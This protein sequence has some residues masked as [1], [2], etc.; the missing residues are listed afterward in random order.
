MKTTLSGK[1]LNLLL[2]ARH[3]D[4][5]SVLGPHVTGRGDRRLVSIGAI[6]RR[7]REIHVLRDAAGGERRTS[8]V[9]VHP[10]G[11]FEPQ[12]TGD[13]QLFT[14]RLE[15]VVHDGF[16]WTQHDAYALG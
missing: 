9:R 6:H 11:V 4:P 5:F 7:A 10:N 12:F 13:H 16:R 1:D 8:M 14:Y 3:W 2:E 15:F